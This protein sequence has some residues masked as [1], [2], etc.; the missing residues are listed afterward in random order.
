[1]NCS[2]LSLLLNFNSIFIKY[3]YRTYYITYYLPPCHWQG[4]HI[5]DNSVCVCAKITKMRH[6]Q[7]RGCQR[8]GLVFD[9]KREYMTKMVSSSRGVKCM[10]LIGVCVNERGG[11]RYSVYYMVSIYIV[12]YLLLLL[13]YI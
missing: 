4:K 1:M 13:F 9:A 11:G 2:S 6:R 7:G 5:I 8:K 10:S 3:F 12:M